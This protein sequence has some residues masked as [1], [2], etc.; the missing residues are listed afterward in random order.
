MVHAHMQLE[1]LEE[2]VQAAENFAAVAANA[3]AKP[4][5]AIRNAVQVCVLNAICTSAREPAGLE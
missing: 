1:Q 4:V 2:L 5:M 3:G